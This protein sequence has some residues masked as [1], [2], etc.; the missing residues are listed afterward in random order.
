MKLKKI[1]A[2]MLAISISASMLTACGTKEPEVNNSTEQNS[3]T[4]TNNEDTQAT[5]TELCIQVQ[6]K[7]MPLQLISLLNHRNYFSNNDR[8]HI[9]F[10]NTSRN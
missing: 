10:C 5:M 3:G 8:Y 4:E 9:L 2:A 7:Q 6:Q 1:L